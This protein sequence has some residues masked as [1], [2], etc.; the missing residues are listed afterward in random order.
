MDVLRDLVLG[1]A[2]F[3]GCLTMH[4]AP[5]ARER[6]PVEVGLGM[7]GHLTLRVPGHWKHSLEVPSHTSSGPTVAFTAPAEE[8]ILQLTAIRH[9]DPD[10]VYR[11]QDVRAML[12]GLLNEPQI[13]QAAEE[14]SLDIHPIG[15]PVVGYWARAADKRPGEEWKYGTFAFV[16]KGQVVL[17]GTLLD[18]ADGPWRQALFEVLQD[19]VHH[20]R[21]DLSLTPLIL[22]PPGKSWAL[23]ID[24]RGF[25][26]EPLQYRP[27]GKGVRLKGSQRES[28]MIVSIALVPALI[29]GDAKAARA[30]SWEKEKRSPLQKE[31]VRMSDRGRLWLVEFTVPR[32]EG[33]EIRQKNVMATLVHD[34]IWADLHLSKPDYAPSDWQRFERVLDSIRISDPR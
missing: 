30:F 15:T 22:R 17:V 4:Q 1:V 27:D 11:P 34:G 12:L 10:S 3:G 24:L 8:F 29:E 16:A 20:A 25:E 33:M 32:F 26:I 14:A 7:H 6:V 5:S 31:E 9:A 13:K 28:G 2:M 18:N 19:A 23:Q 21:V